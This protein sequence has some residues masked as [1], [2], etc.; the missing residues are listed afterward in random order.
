MD[1][2][3]RWLKLIFLGPEKPPR[4]E[5]ERFPL[6][7]R[8]RPDL[9]R[10]TRSVDHYAGYIEDYLAALDSRGNS[11][12]PAQPH[13]SEWQ[14]W[15]Y[16]KGVFGQWGLIARGPADALP[17]VLQLLRHPVAE[18]RQAGAGVLSA[19]PPGSGEFESAAL[20][21]AE[22]E[23]ASPD[24]DIETLGVLLDML[25]RARSDAALPLMARVL[26]DPKSSTGD[27]DWSAIEALEVFAGQRFT[28]EPEPKQAAEQWLQERGL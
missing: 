26:R 27:L 9:A 11:R 22:R 7:A 25:A 4:L 28:K 1:T 10:F 20:A 6:D 5:E 18:G 13:T 12:N 2:V 23:E 16:R 14:A 24:T 15:S 8:G 19:W 21:A 17:V 3:L